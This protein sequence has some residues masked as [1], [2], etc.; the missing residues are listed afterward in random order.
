L[1]TFS[2]VNLII[3]LSLSSAALYAQDS[4]KLT[5]VKDSTQN[6][7]NKKPQKDLVDL[8]RSIILR[9]HTGRSDT[10]QQLAGKAY[11]S[12]LPSAQDA[13]ATGAYVTLTANTAFYTSNA[14]NQ[15]ISSVL[16]SANY[17]QNKQFFL[18]IQANIWL[19]NNKIDIMTDWHFDIFPQVTY[20]LGGYTSD[21]GPD[22]TAIDYTYIRLYQSVMKVIATDMFVGIGY[23]LDY[24]W[25]IALHTQPGVI[26]DFQKYGYNSRSVASGITLNFLYDTRRNSINPSPGYY[27]NVVLRSNFT[28]IGSD[29]NWQSLLVDGRKYIHFPNNSNNTLAFWTYDWFTLSG[30]PPYLNLAN[31]ACDTYL[32]MGRGYVLGRYRGQN[33]LYLET[34]YRFGVTR[35]GLLGGVVFL[36]GQSYSEPVSNKFE[37]ISP[38]YGVGLRIKLNKFSKTNIALDYGWGTHGSQGIFANLGEVF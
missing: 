16:A 27:A 10:G 15:N 17:S 4:L 14:S 38:G 13:P 20:G 36:N 35:N 1:K 37:V 33:L 8:Y 6:T 19:K 32:N 5:S 24:Y 12:L 22:S 25:N 11:F 21:T 23:D 3:Y 7:T 2:K 18:P 34:E 29:N 9:K 26:S 31:T 28:F 30:K